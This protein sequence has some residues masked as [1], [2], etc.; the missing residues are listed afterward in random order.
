VIP[1]NIKLSRVAITRVFLMAISLGNCEWQHKYANYK[2]FAVKD[3][4]TLRYVQ[5]SVSTYRIFD[6]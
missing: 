1:K 5:N 2:V 4:G 3:G 6:L